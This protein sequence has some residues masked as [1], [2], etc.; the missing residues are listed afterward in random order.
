MG[1]AGVPLP[2]PRTFVSKIL[3]GLGLG[4]DLLRSLIAP[5]LM[6][7]LFL[8]VGYEP[9]SFQTQASKSRF[10]VPTSKPGLLQAVRLARI[11]LTQAGLVIA[12]VLTVS[13]ERNQPA[14]ICFR[15][16]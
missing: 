2:P 10:E 9:L 8:C 14:D 12:L 7:P 1:V 6:Q 3:R 4:V 5:F 15:V 13:H 16:V 11:R